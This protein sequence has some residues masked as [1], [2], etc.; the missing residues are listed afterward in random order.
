[1]ICGEGSTHGCAC[2]CVL[3][4]GVGS[5]ENSLSTCVLKPAQL[6]LVEVGWGGDDMDLQRMHNDPF[7]LTV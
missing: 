3:M 7:G 5:T 2:R 6:C 4:F 1:M